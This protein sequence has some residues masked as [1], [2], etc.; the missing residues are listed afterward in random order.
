MGNFL[1]GY[2]YHNYFTLDFSD[3]YFSELLILVNDRKIN[4]TYQQKLKS[5]DILWAVEITHWKLRHY[6]KLFCIHLFIHLFAI[7]LTLAV[8]LHY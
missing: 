8:K 1:H 6:G 7:Y 3:Q 2:S 5:G 4:K